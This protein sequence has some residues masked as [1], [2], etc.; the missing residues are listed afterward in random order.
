MGPATLNAWDLVEAVWAS[1][2][3]R[4]TN[5]TPLGGLTDWDSWSSRYPAPKWFRTFFILIQEPWTWLDSIQVASADLTYYQPSSAHQQSSCCI[6]HNL[7]SW[8]RSK[9]SSSFLPFRL[10]MWSMARVSLLPVG[11]LGQAERRWRGKLP[12][13]V[14]LPIVT[15]WD[16]ACPSATILQWINGEEIFWLKATITAAAKGDSSMSTFSFCNERKRIILKLHQLS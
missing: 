3:W 2:T 8:I 16:P 1:I 12:S 4:T 14:F 13:L 9:D 6:L 10:I 15:M 7:S 5:S 11:T